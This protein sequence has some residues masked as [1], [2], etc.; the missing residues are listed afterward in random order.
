M[1]TC[2]VLAI[3]IAGCGGNSLTDPSSNCRCAAGEPGEKGPTGDGGPQGPPGFQGPQ[4]APGP[5][6][7]QGLPGPQGDPGGFIN[8]SQIYVNESTA[9]TNPGAFVS[10]Q[11]GCTNINHL[12]V[13][14]GCSYVGKNSQLTES[15]P[16]KADVVAISVWTCDLE[17][18]DFGSVTARI[19]CL[20]P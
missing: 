14:G 15:M 11:A 10:V 2:A 8:K 12:L 19:V 16:D 3:F 7:P 18:G 6:G 9:P 4:G 17:S 1:K 20:A 5:M 13:S